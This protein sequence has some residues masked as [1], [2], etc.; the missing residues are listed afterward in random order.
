MDW[1]R[2]DDPVGAVAVHGISGIWVRI[3][4]NYS[5]SLYMYKH[6][7]SVCLSIYLSTSIFTYMDI[8]E[9]LK[10]CVVT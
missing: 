7:V 10:A 5:P 4:H 3:M 6:T 1:M 2:I 9:F 8:F